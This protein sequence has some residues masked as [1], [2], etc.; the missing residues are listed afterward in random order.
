[1]RGSSQNDCTNL[2]FVHEV[3]HLPIILPALTLSGLII[4]DNLV[5]LHLFI[6][7]GFPFWHWLCQFFPILFCLQLVDWQFLFILY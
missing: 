5:L 4:F 7:L 2:I 1:L 6:H 3:C